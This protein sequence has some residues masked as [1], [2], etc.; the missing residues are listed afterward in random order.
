MLELKHTFD[1]SQVTLM[2][3]IHCKTF[4]RLL[5][6]AVK[7]RPGSY[8]ISPHLANILPNENKIKIE[9]WIGGEKK[10]DFFHSSAIVLNIFFAFPDHSPLSTSSPQLQPRHHNIDNFL[11]HHSIV[12]IFSIKT[13]H[14]KTPFY[15]NPSLLLSNQFPKI[16]L[17]FQTKNL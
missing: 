9:N 14:A 11:W 6:S 12:N 3:P 4:Q 13:S 15:T 2:K 8:Q 5:E 10:K 7:Q 1:F 17:H 16:Y